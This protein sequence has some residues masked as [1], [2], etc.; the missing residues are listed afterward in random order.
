MGMKTKYVLIINHSVTVRGYP[1]THVTS[2]LLFTAKQCPIARLHHSFKIHSLW[3]DTWATS[4]LGLLWIK[5][6][7]NICMQSLFG[8][9]ALIFSSNSWEDTAAHNLRSLVSKALLCFLSHGAGRL[10][11]G[12]VGLPSACSGRSLL[13][14]L[15]GSLCSEL[16]CLHLFFWLTS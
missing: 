13:A 3:M 4:N 1:V 16:F 9:D 2:L 15:F 8:Q 6:A 11:T 7:L 5:V 14:C 12:L 10:L